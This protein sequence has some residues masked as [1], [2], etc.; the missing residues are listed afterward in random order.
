MKC[1]S[2]CRTISHAPLRRQS[3]EPLGRLRVVRP[4]TLLSATKKGGGLRA[5]QKIS[6]DR[7][8]QAVHHQLEEIMKEAEDDVKRE[9]DAKQPTRPIP[10]AKQK[11]SSENSQK[12]D[13]AHPDHFDVERFRGELGCMICQP[14]DT[15]DRE[16]ASDDNDGKRSFAHKAARLVCCFSA[17]GEATGLHITIW[18]TR[19][20]SPQK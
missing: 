16:Q 8:Q 6:N 5:K 3:L 18:T 9:P 1:S 20:L 2:K 10:A 15:R 14:D 17:H 13:K 12:P 4:A 11:R 19:M 7:Q